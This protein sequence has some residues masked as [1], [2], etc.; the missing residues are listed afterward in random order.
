MR[1]GEVLSI[2]A[3]KSYDL[4]KRYNIHAC[5]ESKDYTYKD[6]EFVTFRSAG[7]GVM[8]FIFDLSKA[9][10][11]PL[12][13]LDIEN[14]EN[15][16]KEKYN[17]TF[18][19]YLRLKDYIKARKK[20]YTHHE[21]N[22][23]F[24]IFD[25]SN[26][27]YL[28]HQPRL[29]KNIQGHTYFD[30]EE[31]ISG[32]EIVQIKSK[33]QTRVNN[34]DSKKPLENFPIPTITSN[35]QLINPI[36]SGGY[37]S[38]WKAKDEKLDRFVAVKILSKSIPIGETSNL[39]NAEKRYY[40]L[41]KGHAK[42]LA[43]IQHKNVV[44]VHDIITIQD[45]KT[46]ETVQGIMMEYLEGKTLD[47]KRDS[48]FSITDAKFIGNSIIDGLEA[49][50]N[51]SIT[52]NDFHEGNIIISDK[53]EVKII[54]LFD[55][56]STLTLL[57]TI[58]KQSKVNKDFSDL[59]RHLYNLI[60]KCHELEPNISYD[61][62]NDIKDSN[63]FNVIREIFNSS[64]HKQNNQK[65]S[66][67]SNNNIIKKIDFKDSDIYKKIENFRNE[68][69]EKIKSN[70]AP[71]TL[72]NTKTKTI[73]HVIPLK[74]F[75]EDCYYDFDEISNNYNILQPI[76]G[77]PEKT[78]YNIE[79]V[80]RT[81]FGEDSFNSYAQFFRNGIIESVDGFLLSYQN[82][83]PYLNYEPIII[84]AIYNYIKTLTKL[85]LPFPVVVFISL[86][87]AK[88]LE[89]GLKQH[90]RYF[91]Q[92]SKIEKDDLFLPE[93]IL[94]NNDKPLELVLKPCFDMIWNACGLKGS[95]N[96]NKEGNWINEVET[97]YRFQT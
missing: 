27:S 39:L 19:E 70:N 3:G 52:H 32:Q 60:L 47:Q 89:M 37:A 95:Y 16:L 86:I 77:R 88:G 22:L 58:S 79:G 91:S 90:Q 59:R 13:S 15:F 55:D 63:D 5:P 69:I 56:R 26:I 65:I 29:E 36:A 34:N 12:E 82:A 67:L 68:R 76:Y 54:D 81:T 31:L 10:V 75:N 57:S 83:I 85:E 7:G 24:Y 23:R 14:S 50:H 25:K 92:D 21:E 30:L 74:S 45:P 20:V 73:I 64:F 9:K 40:D 4:I 51:Q 96:Y 11:F 38:V 18:E 43:K 66:T 94:E 41:I 61:F 84:N 49:I 2:P 48:A 72:T 97:I 71:V 78:K 42:S 87:G 53:K 80:A 6:S 35:I 46:S 44:T 93:I 17:I 33:K 8:E 62:F 1:I 28:N